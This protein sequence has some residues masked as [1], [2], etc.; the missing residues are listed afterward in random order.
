MVLATAEI[1]RR[2]SSARACTLFA[3]A[4]ATLALFANAVL[5]SATTAQL[6]RAQ[7]VVLITIDGLAAF[8]LRN[9]DIDL[10]HL[11]AL[12]AGG[13]SGSA[14]TSFPSMTH[15]AHTTLITGTTPRQHGVVNNRVVDRRTGQRFHITNLSRAESIKVPTLFDAVRQAGGATAALFWPETKDDPAIV[16][17]ITEVFDAREMADPAAVAP[18]LMAE[19]R[20]AGVPIDSYYSFYDDPFAQGA[21]DLAL[22]RAA[23]YLFAARRPALLALHLLVTDKVQHEFGA[24]HYLTRAALTTA[25]HAV[26]VL[27]EAIAKA[28]LADRTTIVIA[29]DHGFVTVRDEINLAPVVA[30]PSLQG[31]VRWSADGWYA[32]AERLPSFDPGRDGPALERVLQRLTATAGI[33]RIV[34]PGEFAALGFP[35]YADNPYVPGHYLIA[36]EISAH[37]ALDDKAP[38]GRRPRTRPYHGH[39]YFPDDPAMHAALIFAGAGIAKGRPF[40]HVRNIDVAPTIAQLLGIRLPS[41]T[42]R[43]L[44]SILE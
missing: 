4:A 9:P 10:P 14:E 16:D 12:A 29:A 43:V 26:G 28:G 19:L 37:V 5:S 24:D 7:H 40:G 38:A 8:H 20:T 21:A 3:I 23:T 13:A 11:R 30:E 31:R 15:P 42:G 18:A 36:S 6:Q 39:G 44:T 25:D 22:T 33:A 27:R 1:I 35:D 17:N 41:A 34:R 2:A 32:W